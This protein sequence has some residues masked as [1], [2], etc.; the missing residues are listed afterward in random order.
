[1]IA[2]WMNKRVK[3]RLSKLKKLVHTF[4]AGV[5]HYR[6]NENTAFCPWLPDGQLP[7]QNWA[8]LTVF[9]GVCQKKIF[10]M[11]LASGRFW[12]QL[13]W[14][15]SFRSNPFWG[16]FLWHFSSHNWLNLALLFLMQDRLLKILS[17]FYSGKIYFKYSW[18]KICSW[19][20]TKY[21]R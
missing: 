18:K 9:E 19:K 21:T 17:D 20:C 11:E 16:P 13:T 3:L 1:M 5:K 12:H 2:H 14:S 4:T 10:G 8:N 6:L 7:G 15:K